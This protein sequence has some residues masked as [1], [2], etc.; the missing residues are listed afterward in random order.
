VLEPVP[1]VPVDVPAD[2][3]P[4]DVEVDVAAALVLEVPPLELLPLELP[5]ELLAA[6]PAVPPVVP[7]P[8]VPVVPL[9]VGLLLEPP[10]ELPPVVNED[11]PEPVVEPPSGHMHSPKP[12]S[13]LQIVAPLMPSPQSHG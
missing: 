6:L 10:L 5:P 7:P 4:L 3:P 9:D 13:P 1:E 12:P 8:L 2:D 11:K